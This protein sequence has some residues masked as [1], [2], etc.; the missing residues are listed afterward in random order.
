MEIITDDETAIRLPVTNPLQM[1]K[2]IAQAVC[3]LIDNPDLMGKMGEAGRA[4]I[5]NEFN[6]EKKR[7]FMESL[8]ND[9]DKKCWKQ[10]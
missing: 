10:K 1:P 8:L 5:K 7:E 6:W 9:L 2:D 3:H 4:R